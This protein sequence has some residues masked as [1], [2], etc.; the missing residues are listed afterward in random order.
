MPANRVWR[1]QRGTGHRF[2][3]TSGGGGGLVG[4][5]EGGGGGEGCAGT[6]W[7]LNLKSC[8]HRSYFN[9]HQVFSVN[10]N[11]TRKKSL[12]TRVADSG[13]VFPDPDP[14]KT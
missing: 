2:I 4:Q 6:Q 1:S 8:R 11:I 14:D 10:V 12:M 5:G 3:C 13:N 7:S 9:N